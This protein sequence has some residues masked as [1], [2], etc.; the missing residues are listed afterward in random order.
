MKLAELSEQSAQS[1]PA[2]G[3]TSNEERAPL[4]E[5]MQAMD[6]VDTLRHSENLVER[7]LNAEDR[8]A[9]LIDRLRDIYRSQGIEVTD[10]V[11]EQGVQALEE[12]RF[13]YTPPPETFA[14]RMARMYVRRNLWGKPV[15]LLLTFV[16]VALAGYLFMVKLPQMREQA[17]L[18]ESINNTF[19][20]IV[21]V[22]ESSLATDRAQVLLQDA[23][24]A[25]DNTDYPAA[26]GNRLELERMLQNLQSEYDLRILARPNELSGVWRVPS[27]NPNARNYYLIVEAIDKDGDRLRL[28]IENEEDGKI[29]NVSKWGIRVEEATFEAVAADKRDDGIIQGDVI[30]RKKRGKLTPDYLVPTTGD[31]ITDW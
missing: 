2:S 9:R 26:N 1:G 11:L 27:I 31:T 15:A 13:R 23:R 3:S 30:G 17:A 24:A 19:G 21:Q 28:P 4:D 5:L 14:T 16:L 18:P 8:R 22:A 12:D 7:E 6:V 29:R 20:Q 25:I 10:A